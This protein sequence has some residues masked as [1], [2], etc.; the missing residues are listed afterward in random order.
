LEVEKDRVYEHAKEIWQK[1]Q[2]Q[3]LWN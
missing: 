1:A 3:Q 2:Q